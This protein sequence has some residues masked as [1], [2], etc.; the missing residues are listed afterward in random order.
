M[1]KAVVFDLFET[2]ITE[3][4]SD[5][6]LF[7]QCAR[8]LGIDPN[9]FKSLWE[10]YGTALSTG[11]M[12][13]HQV[14]QQICRETGVCVPEERVTQCQAKRVAGKEQCFCRMDPDVLSMLSA[15]KEKGLQLALCSNCSQDEIRP[16][17]TSPLFSFFDAV[18]LSYQ[19]GLMKPDPAIYH[20]CAGKLSVSPEACLFV[21]DGGS[22]E[23]YGAENAGLHAL[24]A[25]WFQEKYHPFI[26]PMP[27]P[28][29]HKPEDVLTAIIAF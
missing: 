16:L 28:S 14:L 24:R 4:V 11:R 21:G 19:V 6:Y 8:D 26:E 25:L 1:I 27:F 10:K 20:L 7:S 3:W 22:R 23:L 2:L 9:M 17:F 18:I 15:L 13:Y 5:K 12:N 29:A